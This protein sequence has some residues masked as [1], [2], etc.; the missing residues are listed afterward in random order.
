M[1]GWK[2]MVTNQN[3]PQ[4][5]NIKKAKLTDQ[6]F[7]T[8]KELILTEQWPAGYK[9]PSEPELANQLG[10]SRMSLRMALQ[11]LQ[12]LGLI[13]VQVGNGTYVKE[14]SVST[15]FEEIGSLLTHMASLQDILELR[16]A[17]EGIGIRL[18]V[19]R[20]SPEQMEQLKRCLHN[21]HEA[22]LQ[23]DREK[24]AKADA[25]FHECIIEMSG[26]KLLTMIYRLCSKTFLDYF[27]VTTTTT[28]ILPPDYDFSD[29]LHMRIYKALEKGDNEEANRVCIETIEHSTLSWG[30]NNS[31]EAK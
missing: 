5:S 11:K 10:V 22:V 24:I 27:K 16:I 9:L 28:K 20:H 26:N 12:T 19:Q 23:Y 25:N 6:I 3:I 18:A 8:I 2:I 30:H 4:V 14:I 7:D 15:Y 29:E 1:L 17:L 21:F 31:G 13:E